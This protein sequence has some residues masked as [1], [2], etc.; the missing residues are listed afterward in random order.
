MADATPQRKSRADAKLD[1]RVVAD[2]PFFAGPNRSK[3]HKAAIHLAEGYLSER[4]IARELNI[5][6]STLQE[7]KQEPDFIE[8]QTEYEQI[9][10][11][12]CL[13]LSIANK[14]DRLQTLD[15]L[16]RKGKEIIRARQERYGREL[17]EAESPENATRRFFGDDTPPEAATGLMVR[18][19]TMSATGQ[20]V[21]NWAYDSALAKD[22]KDTE[23]Q[24]AQELGQWD[25]GKSTVDMQ[26]TVTAIRIIGED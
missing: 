22:L 1:H 24:A 9:I 2:L 23:K 18:N 6:R 7:W 8:V 13:N 17:A 14:L 21:V 12:D 11:A 16:Y 19:V 10:R 20:K 5:A 4:A 26:Q 15:M 25:E 3:K